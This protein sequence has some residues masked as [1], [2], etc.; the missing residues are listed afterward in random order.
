MQIYEKVKTKGCKQ[1]S[2]FGK[3]FLGIIYSY[4]HSGK[5]R[6]DVKR[7][8]WGSLIIIDY[9]Q[10]FLMDVEFVLLSNFIASSYATSSASHWTE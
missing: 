5:E 10:F 9:N 3:F 6:G 2:Y 7:K 4:Y 8:V 1:C